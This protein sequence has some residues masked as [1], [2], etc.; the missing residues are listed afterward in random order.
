MRFKIPITVNAYIIIDAVYNKWVRE[1]RQSDITEFTPLG[2]GASGLAFPDPKFGGGFNR[3]LD[4]EQVGPSFLFPPGFSLGGHL[5]WPKAQQIMSE[6]RAI[7]HVASAEIHPKK[8]VGGGLIWIMEGVFSI[9]LEGY[10][11]KRITN[12]VSMQLCSTFRR[13]RTF[14]RWPSV[15]ANPESGGKGAASLLLPLNLNLPPRYSPCLSTGLCHRPSHVLPF[16]PSPS[17]GR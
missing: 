7:R 4:F 2:D 8:K 9:G 13:V 16:R 5:L 14:R 6:C 11:R 3:D 15:W 17:S 12:G 10:R 1:N